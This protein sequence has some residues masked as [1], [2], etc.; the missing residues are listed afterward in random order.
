MSRKRNRYRLVAV[1]GVCVALAGWIYQSRFWRARRIDAA[2]VA[3]AAAGRSRAGR[4]DRRRPDG[5]R[6]PE[7]GRSRRSRRHAHL[8]PEP[9]QRARESAA[10]PAD[11]PLLPL[12]GREAGHAA[13]MLRNH[14]FEAFNGGG[15]A[16]LRVA[17][18][19]SARR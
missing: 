17:E 4:R 2:R 6:I 18:S 1:L 14:G 9:A 11:R 12:R 13:K 5:L 15:V 16:E 8:P 19:R 7:A 3:G 10:E